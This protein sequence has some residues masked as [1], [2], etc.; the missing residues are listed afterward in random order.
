MKSVVF[1]VSIVFSFCSVAQKK[2]VLK[3]KRDGKI[4]PTVIIG[5]QTWMTE[6]LNASTFRNGDPIPEAKSKEEWEK[7]VKEK[8]PAWCYLNNR[9]IQDDPKNGDK[10][11][12][13]YNWWAVIDSR[14]LAPK[15][16]HIP[17]DDEWTILVNNLDGIDEAGGK[18]KSLNT[19]W[20]IKGEYYNNSGFSA[21]PMGWRDNFGDF[22]GHYETGSIG[23]NWWSSSEDENNVYNFSVIELIN[24][25]NSGKN[26]TK[27]MRNKYCEDCFSF[28]IRC[29]KD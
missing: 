20:K 24:Y 27:T 13:L 17:S 26:I 25:Q 8:R 5:S 3:D 2:E 12:K 7:A 11:G 22:H 9:S 23:C 29:V 6:N 18:L 4:Y 19:N 21:L 14:G 28:A 15:G 10:Y 1:I 16:W